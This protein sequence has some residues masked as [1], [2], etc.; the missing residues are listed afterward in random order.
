MSDKVAQRP[1][2][3]RAA[4]RP[5]LTISQILESMQNEAD[6]EYNGDLPNNALTIFNAL[7]TDDKR[8]F[9]RKGLEALWERQIAYAQE[10]LQEIVLAGEVVASPGVPA[11]PEVRISPVEIRSER[12]SIDGAAPEEQKKL[13]QWLMKLMLVGLFFMFIGI[14][15]FTSFYG[16][17]DAKTI[18]EAAGNINTLI[19]LL[20][21]ADK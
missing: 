13:R 11:K 14:M 4:R 7:S 16:T 8:T 10:G 15:I 20:L 21:K 12:E 18:F 3:R 6:S 9:L 17:Y 19:E 5:R 2:E 1:R